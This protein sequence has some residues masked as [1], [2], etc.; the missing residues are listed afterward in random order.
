MDREFEMSEDVLAP[1]EP[2]SAK[3]ADENQRIIDAE[4][5]ERIARA[6][7]RLSSRVLIIYTIRIRI[8]WII[9]NA[10]G[11]N[12]LVK[13]RAAVWTQYLHSIKRYRK[14]RDITLNE[15]NKIA[16]HGKRIDKRLVGLS[17]ILSIFEHDLDA[18]R[19]HR[20]FSVWYREDVE[21]QNAMARES[22]LWEQQLQAAFSQLPRLHH[23][24]QDQRGNWRTETPHI[25]DIF[26]KPDRVLYHVKTTSQSMIERLLG[27]FH[28]A[29]PYGVSVSALIERETLENLSAFTNRVVTV[30]R[31]S[32][33]T[34]I[35]YVINRADSPDGIQSKVM[36]QSLIDWYPA[37]DHAKTP[38]IAGVTENR[39]VKF[40]NFEDQP[41]VLIAGSTL[42]GKS[43]HI[44]Q[45]IALIATMNT[46][47]EVQFILV[48]LKGGIE[49]THWTG[50]KHQLRPMVK[51]SLQILGEL[52]YLRGVMESRLA[53]FERIRAKNL[54]S[55]NSKADTKLA[56]IILV[57]DEMATL[58]GL[59]DL[60]TQIHAELR[61]LS[62]Q[63]RAVGIHLILC[64]QHSSVDVLPGWIKTN[65]G[66]RVSAKMPSHTASLVILDSISASLLPD[67]PGR[68]VFSVGRSETIAQSPYISDA[69]I[70]SVV[71]N[72]LNELEKIDEQTIQAKPKFSREDLVKISLE[73]MDGKLS[74]IRIHDAINNNNEMCTLRN[75]RFIVDD[76]VDDGGVEY[77]GVRYSVK[78][79]RNSYQLIAEP[80]AEPV[81]VDLLVTPT[82]TVETEES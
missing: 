76:I 77:D 8:L 13:K 7:S 5:A 50:L 70:E 59:G 28:S 12:N 16:R 3:I 45:M 21:R 73:R 19:N 38:W 40:Y 78:K 18:L 24:Y 2:F 57:V 54:M 69:V 23:R 67:V 9:L 47:R 80:V 14:K 63:G 66:L 4:I 43:N 61:V 71:K 60:T 32:A 46:P 58:I 74:P 72:S 15:I 31:S 55:Y 64:T 44:N 26:I 81:D 42:G 25:V 11:Y 36:Y 39:M 1:L 53:I 10:I 79:S 62:S 48:D 20:D 82:I 22:R 52:R 33:G 56:R 34:N 68:M 51:D 30:E 41:H 29:L 37:K 75:I 35:F 27:R 17:R 65:M 6:G 49:F